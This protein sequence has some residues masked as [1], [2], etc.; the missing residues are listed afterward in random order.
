MRKTTRNGDKNFEALRM[1]VW[2]K[3]IGN[4]SIAKGNHYYDK[5]SKAIFQETEYSLS[6]DTIRNFFED[7]HSPSP[8]TLDIY[9]T[10]VLGYDKDSPK[11]Y[12][13]FQTWSSTKSTRYNRSIFL[14][15]DRHRYLIIFF[16]L[17]I[18][19][20]LVSLVLAKQ[21]PERKVIETEDPQK[22]IEFST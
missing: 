8:K 3:A 20:F 16:A 21:K 2:R 4:G 5:I 18:I 15:S 12:S 9:S 10:Y 22:T 17:V 6:K 11:T 13:D 7:K 14:K 1:E 19:I